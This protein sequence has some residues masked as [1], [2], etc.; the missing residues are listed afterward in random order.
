MGNSKRNTYILNPNVIVPDSELKASTATGV[1]VDLSPNAHA[2]TPSSTL[3]KTFNRYGGTAK[4]VEFDGIDQNASF[5]PITISKN[6]GA[7]R[8]RFKLNGYVAGNLADR[9]CFFSNTSQSFSQLLTSVTSGIGNFTG[10]TNTNNDRF[11]NLTS[12]LEL[13][14]WYDIIFNFKSNVCRT[15]ISGKMIDLQSITD[16]LTVSKLNG[17]Q[18]ST[19][20]TFSNC[21]IDKFEIRDTP[22]SEEEMKAMYKEYPS[23]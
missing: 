2:I 10:E 22:F 21:V 13:E 12:F 6:S 16:D 15:Y 23:T 9:Q 17:V 20:K 7:F 1:L 19:N 3:A 18:I 4:A 5:T 14:K 8:I 11:V